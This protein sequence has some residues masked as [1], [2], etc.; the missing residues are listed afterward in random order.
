MSCFQ[1]FLTIFDAKIFF[2]AFIHFYF[3]MME[4]YRRMNLQFIVYA[5]L[6]EE[7]NNIK[8]ELCMWVWILHML[9]K[10]NVCLRRSLCYPSRMMDATIAIVVVLKYSWALMYVRE[11]LKYLKKIPFVL[12]IHNYYVESLL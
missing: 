4:I 7:K 6:L 3:Q 12:Y 8:E 1:L 11:L 2:N 5:V 9:I 10:L